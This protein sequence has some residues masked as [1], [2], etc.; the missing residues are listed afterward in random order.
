[1]GGLVSAWQL[2]D[3]CTA[4]GVVFRPKNGMLNPLLTMGKPS[5]DLLQRVKVYKSQILD[6]LAQMT[7]FSEPEITT[8]STKT[9][10]EK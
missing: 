3:E 10:G 5:N 2:I 4:A 1:M 8:D 7:D 6:C 9:Q